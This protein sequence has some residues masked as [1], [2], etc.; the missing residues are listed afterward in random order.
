MRG[1]SEKV[2]LEGIVRRREVAEKGGGRECKERRR[3]KNER[4]KKAAR[5]HIF[6]YVLYFCF[7]IFLN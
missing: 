3:I 1:N 5:D 2:D 6:N 4:S 7:Y